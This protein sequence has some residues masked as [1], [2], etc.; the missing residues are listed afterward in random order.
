MNT[1]TKKINKKY[2]LLWTKNQNDNLKRDDF[3]VEFLIPCLGFDTEPKRQ[4]GKA[5]QFFINKP[6][7][8]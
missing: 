5:F 7:C 8:K 1:G 4:L 3:N 2:Q 6:K